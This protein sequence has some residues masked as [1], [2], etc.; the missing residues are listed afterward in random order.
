MHNC[1][2]T[3]LAGKY[4]EAKVLN[5]AILI[6]EKGSRFVWEAMHEFNSTYRIV[7]ILSKQSKGFFSSPLVTDITLLDFGFVKLL[8]F[9]VT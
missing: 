4:G 3:E 8:L 1:L 9:C 2:G 7:S 5:G 6:F